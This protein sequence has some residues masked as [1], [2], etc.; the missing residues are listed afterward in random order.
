PAPK[1]EAAPANDVT[2]SFAAAAMAAGVTDAQAAED[3]HAAFANSTDAEVICI[4]RPRDPKTPSRTVIIHQASPKLVGYLLDSV[5]A[6]ALPASPPNV[7]AQTES[8][9]PTTV[10]QRV[11]DMPAAWPRTLTEPTRPLSP[12]GK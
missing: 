5:D 9:I 6:P 11:T 10:Q 1:T 7:L 2:T 4:V 8:L 3:L 12:R